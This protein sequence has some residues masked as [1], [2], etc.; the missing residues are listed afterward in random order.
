MSDGIK[1]V[2]DDARW[3]M[4]LRVTPRLKQMLD[5]KSHT[6]HKKF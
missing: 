6:K 5:L 3:G 4:A 1:T 2:A